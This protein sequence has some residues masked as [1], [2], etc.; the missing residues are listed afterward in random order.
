MWFSTWNK[1]RVATTERFQWSQNLSRHH[2]WDSQNW[3]LKFDHPSTNFPHPIFS[4][5]AL[6][7]TNNHKKHPQSAPL[8]LFY[9]SSHLLIGSCSKC[10]VCQ[11]LRFAHSICP[12][13]MKVKPWKKP[14]LILILT[15]P[16][17]LLYCVINDY[18]LILQNA[19]GTSDG[20]LALSNVC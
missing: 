1:A 19:G 11:T 16:Y 10:Y 4:S 2:D 6:K 8:D 18:V 13:S 12:K 5:K 20:I 14:A 15:N 9:I 7:L 17:W 3:T